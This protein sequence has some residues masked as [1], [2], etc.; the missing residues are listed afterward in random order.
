[1]GR[2]SYSALFLLAADESTT[3]EDSYVCSMYPTVCDMLRWTA[4][5]SLVPGQ[6]PVET[7]LLISVSI[8]MK[9][10]NGGLKKGVGQGWPRR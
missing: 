1:M 5:I 4:G 3:K 6:P 10:R 7:E 2:Y 8:S 9:P